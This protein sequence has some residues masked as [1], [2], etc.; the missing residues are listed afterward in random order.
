MLPNDIIKLIHS[1]AAYWPDDW[2]PIQEVKRHSY[3]WVPMVEDLVEL[4]TW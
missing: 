1:F 3:G 2:K 4:P